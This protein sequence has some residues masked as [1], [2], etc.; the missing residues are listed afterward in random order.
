MAR[1]ADTHAYAH[2]RTHVYTRAPAQA[3]ARAHERARTRAHICAE[4]RTPLVPPHP[5]TPHP[6]L[7]YL[8]L[9]P[10]WTLHATRHELTTGGS[11]ASG[12]RHGRG[13]GPPRSPRTTKRGRG[14]RPEQRGQLTRGDGAAAGTG[15]GAGEG[16]DA[17]ARI[18][19]GAA[20]EWCR[21]IAGYAIEWGRAGGGRKQ[22]RNVRG[23][24]SWAG[25]AHMM[26][27]TTGVFVSKRAWRRG[28]G[29]MRWL[30]FKTILAI[31]T[32][33]GAVGEYV[34][35]PIAALAAFGRTGGKHILYHLKQSVIECREGTQLML[36]LMTLTRTVTVLAAQVAHAWARR[37]ATWRTGEG[38]HTGRSKAGLTAGTGADGTRERGHTG[39]EDTMTDERHAA[40]DGPD[41]EIEEEMKG[42]GRSRACVA[43][44][45]PKTII[46]YNCNGIGVHKKGRDATWGGDKVRVGKGKM[47][48]EVQASTFFPPVG[49]GW[50]GGEV[51]E[52]TGKAS[53]IRDYFRERQC[54]VMGLQETKHGDT[55]AAARYLAPGEGLKAWGTPG[56]LKADGKGARRM[57]A[58][59]MIMW[60]ESA[61]VRCVTRAVIAKH[62]IISAVMEMPGR[63]RVKVV[64]AYMDGAK[65]QGKRARR[66]EEERWEALLR[67]ASGDRVV[68]LGDLNTTRDEQ[69]WAGNKLREVMAAGGLNARGA[70]EATHARGD[71]EIDHVMVGSGLAGVVGR[72]VV[73]D[74]DN[75]TKKDHRAVV[76]EWKREHEAER[77]M[78]GREER[79]RAPD[80]GRV[81]SEWWVKARKEM[82]DR[83]QSTR[84]AMAGKGAGERLEGLQGMVMA[85][86]KKALEGQEGADRDRR[87]G[88][89]GKG[90]RGGGQGKG[91]KAAQQGRDGGGAGGGAGGHGQ[92][93]V[94]GRRARLR[95]RLRKWRKLAV[96]A[97]GYD[98]SRRWK[99]GAGGG[100]MWDEGSLREVMLD[101]ELSEGERMEAVRAIIDSRY[102]EALGR[103]EECTEVKPNK[104]VTGVRDA[105]GKATGGGILHAVHQYLRQYLDR[106]GGGGDMTKLRAMRVGGGGSGEEIT[107]PERVLEEARRY[108]EKQLGD[109]GKAWRGTMREAMRWVGGGAHGWEEGGEA[110][111][112]ESRRK[113]HVNDAV[114]R[115]MTWEKFEKAVSKAVAR[116]ASADGFSVYVLKQAPWKVR[117]AF[118]EETRNVVTTGDIPR[119]WRDWVAM[120]AMKPGEEADD[121]SRRRD[122]WLVAG[123]QKIV[124]ICM[125]EEYERA[126]DDTVPGSAS[127]FTRMR[128]GPEQT[129]VARLTREHAANTRGVV[130][131]AWIDYSQL[132]MSVV[133][134]CQWETERFCGV[135]PGVTEIVRLLHE[136]VT[137]RYETAYGLTPRYPVR[138]GTGQGCVNGATRA[139]LF[140]T[141]TQRVVEKACKG[142]GFVLDPDR[143]ICQGWYADDACLDASSPHDL[144][145]MV[146]CCW[147]VARI[148]GLKI[149]VK[150]KKKTAWS[151][152]YW[153]QDGRGRMVEKDIECGEWRMCMPD[154]TEVPQIKMG[155]EQDV[156]HYKHLGSEMGPGFTGGQE[157]VRAKVVARCV[158][159]IG[160]IGGI[161]GLGV[162]ALND[163]IES[164]IGGIVDYYGR[165]CVLTWEDME[166]VERARA[167]AV[168]RATGI[169]AVPRRLLWGTEASGCMGRKHMYARAAEALFDQIDRMLS[170]GTG[171]PG[172]VAVESM[173]AD[174]CYRLGCRGCSPL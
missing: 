94:Q 11:A 102:E 65:A 171:E 35:P 147:M 36:T 158:G 151:G 136:E 67:E 80:M 78:E 131:T 153:T 13:G 110:M 6:T 79:A 17:R 10:T 145:K 159:V 56:V 162:K 108:G 140:L 106:G 83:L 45:G 126:G 34:I 165:A 143:H 15:G 53:R 60:D 41:P 169:W 62:R 132:F 23:Q 85:A 87:G 12:S 7:P 58:G 54:M 152:T 144:R 105:V 142:Y 70:G 167:A 72:A 3:H 84:L 154:G 21:A 129:V 104:F 121:L 119:A 30:C 57:T 68:L 2:A 73:D 66:A 61:G 33:L 55:A 91:K 44:D 69:G 130:C 59:V 127:G 47:G 113:E 150:G 8:T 5:T 48:T 123:M 88:A 63:E 116:K 125:K 173:I 163:A 115:Y 50:D 86:A 40:G 97:R 25:L 49:E 170:G 135:H 16:E 31:A 139:K 164:A 75:I 128:N 46:T 28:V 112:S 168:Q 148:S 156:D 124:Q 157:R 120:L 111:E 22:G 95:E 89:G 64:V 96:V 100:C 29:D 122:L 101:D 51:T 81:R 82:E 39:S 109:P 19:A 99:T 42:L 107:E 24:G 1:A 93:V 52:E 166:K 71:R 174:T 172:R 37:A 149:N 18:L 76:A 98:G 138:R 27:L 14:G 160:V 74:M 141:L 137:G 77:N 155:T 146:E 134:S 114:E 161:Q 92:T 38:R 32:T 4:G 117:R 20:V 43:Y 90:A 118:W 103:L 9:P 133:K 26:T